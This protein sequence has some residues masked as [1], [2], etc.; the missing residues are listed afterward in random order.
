M[1][2]RTAVEFL[3]AHAV[4]ANRAAIRERK[5]SGNWLLIEFYKKARDIYMVQAR[6][7]QGSTVGIQASL[8]GQDPSM[9]RRKPGKAAF[10]QLT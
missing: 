8:A 3:V 6:A 2:M 7:H 1:A 10:S 4:T 9:D 5:L